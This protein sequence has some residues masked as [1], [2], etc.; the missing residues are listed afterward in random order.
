MSIEFGVCFGCG[1]F[2][3][4]KSNDYPY[5]DKNYDSV[6]QVFYNAALMDS[7][8]A[9]NYSFS[10]QF[11]GETYGMVHR[12]YFKFEEHF[13]KYI[14]DYI[15]ENSDWIL[16]INDDTNEVKNQIYPN[17]AKDKLYISNLSE[18]TAYEIY[19]NF[20]RKVIS[21]NYQGKI[22]VDDLTSGM[23][24]IRYEVDNQLQR[25]SFIIM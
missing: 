21:R 3:F 16:T 8:N 13:T 20:G 7:K 15:D 17:P 4:G 2:Y 1:T 12:E 5:A 9:D 6:S 25:K 22:N 23:Y 24:F 11:F 18:D 14:Y 10:N 19:D